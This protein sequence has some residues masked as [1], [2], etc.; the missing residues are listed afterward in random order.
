[1]IKIVNINVDV[2]KENYIF[3][4]YLINIFC[5]A[6]FDLIKLCI[7]KTLLILKCFHILSENV[8]FKTKKII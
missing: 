8:I 2:K 4:I 3:I 5:G 7:G 1:M 6:R